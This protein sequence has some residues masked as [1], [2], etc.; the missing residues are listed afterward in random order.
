MIM[1]EIILALAYLGFMWLVFMSGFHYFGRWTV[2]RPGLWAAVIM[3]LVVVAVGW[4]RLMGDLAL[5][6]L[7]LF[8]VVAYQFGS[9]WLGS[10]KDNSD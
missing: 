2:N 9:Y 6:V 1:Y 7:I 3:I 4:S 5:P 8:L 10:K